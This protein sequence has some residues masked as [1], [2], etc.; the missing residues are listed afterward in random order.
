[1]MNDDSLIY[2]TGKINDWVQIKVDPDTNEKSFFVSDANKKLIQ[3]IFELYLSNLSDQ[4]IANKLNARGVLDFNGNAWSNHRIKDIL[5]SRSVIG[6]YTP[7][8]GIEIDRQEQLRIV[9][10]AEW[11]QVQEMRKSK[12]AK[13]RKCTSGHIFNGLVTCGYCKAKQKNKRD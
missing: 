3:E 2:N 9:S 8:K 5:N 11:H 12:V 6:K 1:M 7:K 4:Q 10:D 13:G